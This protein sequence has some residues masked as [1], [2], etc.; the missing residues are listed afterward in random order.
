MA[1][2]GQGCAKKDVPETAELVT[3]G[4]AYLA[5]FLVNR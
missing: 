5:G 4:I 2:Y 3:A 1:M